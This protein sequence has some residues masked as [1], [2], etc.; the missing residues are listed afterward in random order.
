MALWYEQN[1]RK[2]MDKSKKDMTNCGCHIAIAVRS[3]SLSLL[4]L[5]FE[6]QS[7]DLSLEAGI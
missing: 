3:V 5:G 4:L 2:G 1:G 6:P 7:W